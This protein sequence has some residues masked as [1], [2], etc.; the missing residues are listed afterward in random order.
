M[1]LPKIISYSPLVVVGARVEAVQG[2]IW[3]FKPSP[4]LP[5]EQFDPIMRGGGQLVGDVG[6]EPAM[7]LALGRN[8]PL[9]KGLVEHRHRGLDGQL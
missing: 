4:E 5:R 7:E 6:A 2:Q 8:V 1:F 3:Q 9:V